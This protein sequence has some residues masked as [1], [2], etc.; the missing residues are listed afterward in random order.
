MGTGS[1]DLGFSMCYSCWGKTSAPASE[2]TASEAEERLGGPLLRE[3]IAVLGLFGVGKK[4]FMA[5][6]F[7]KEHITASSRRRCQTTAL[8]YSYTDFL[9]N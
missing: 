4:P 3:V 7:S 9:Q 8:V 2:R 1:A 6:L 5:S